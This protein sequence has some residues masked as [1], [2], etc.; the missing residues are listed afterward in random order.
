M[1]SLY[2]NGAPAPCPPGFNMAAHVLAPAERTPAKTALTVLS[3]GVEGAAGPFEDWSFAALRAAVL[4]TAAALRASGLKGGDVVALRLGNTVDFPIA[5][6]G[7]IAAD[8]VPVPLSSQLTAHELR[9]MLAELAPR[10]IAHDPRLTLPEDACGAAMPLDLRTLRDMRA[11]APMAPVPGDPDRLGYIVYTSGTSGKPR[12]VMH[13]HRA[14]WARQMMWRDWYDLRADDRLLHA[15]AFNWTYTLGTGLMDPWAAGATSLIAAEG[16]AIASLP[17]LLRASRA[18]L[19]AAAPGVYRKLLTPAPA[20]GEPET[21]GPETSASGTNCNAAPGPHMLRL[22]L[23]H[24]RHAL[25]AGEKLPQALALAWQEATGTRI[26][27]ALGMSECSTFVSSSPTRPAGAASAGLPQRGRRLAVLDQAGAPVPR[28]TPGTLAVA[29]TDPGLM[30][31]YLGQPADTAARFHAGWFL[32]GD[33]VTMDAHDEITYLGRSDDMMN[34]GGYRV[35]PLEVEAAF[36]DFAGLTGAAAA[37][38]RVKANTHVIALFYT[39]DAPLPDAVLA[40]HAARHLARYKT[41]RIYMHLDALAMNA[42]GKLNR[43][44]MRQAYE[45][46]HDQA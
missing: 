8:I 10:A 6:L 4:G 17:A 46:R 42:N 34:A 39:S 22:P 21:T 16:T 35:S 18:T 43:R 14:V 12:A 5:Y 3:A 45:A 33:T 30:L 13:A 19:F 27:E 9:P 25:S 28:G 2:D 26:Y 15:G 44:A 11:H 32:T 31:G 41:P 24:L 40:E 36:A 1:L 29:D 38:V 23:P 37:E 20:P 7:C